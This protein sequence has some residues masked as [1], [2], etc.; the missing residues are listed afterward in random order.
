[1][2]EIM[3]IAGYA[4]FRKFRVYAKDSGNLVDWVRVLLT[5]ITVC[6]IAFSDSALKGRGDTTPQG[7]TDSS[8]SFKLFFAFTVFFRWMKV[9]NSLRGYEFAGALILPVL[10]SLP[11][12]I[13][14]LLVVI[15][16]TMGLMHAYYIFNIYG[17][18]LFRSFMIIYRICFVGDFDWE[19]MEDIDGWYLLPNMTDPDDKQLELEDPELSEWHPFISVILVVAT[20]FVTITMMNI[21]IAVLCDAFGKAFQE[22]DRAFWRTRVR[23]VL[24]ESIKMWTEEA[25]WDNVCRCR[26]PRRSRR[27]S[28][29][30]S[31]PDGSD[32]SENQASESLPHSGWDYVWYCRRSQKAITVSDGH[33]DAE[34][35][36][37]EQDL[38]ELKNQM[39]E[40]ENMVLEMTHAVEHRFDNIRMQY[41][42]E[43]GLGQK[44]NAARSH[45]APAARRNERAAAYA[46][47]FLQSRFQSSASRNSVPAASAGTQF[48]LQ[49]H[50]DA[51]SCMPA[52]PS[53]FGNLAFAL[54]AASS[55]VGKAARTAEE[56]KAAD[57]DH[58]TVST[59]E[60]GALLFTGSGSLPPVPPPS[61]SEI[62]S[63]SRTLPGSIWA[64]NES[65]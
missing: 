45:S 64:E 21:F 6:Y 53:P 14:F 22:R 15:F 40:L 29:R 25:I 10:R 44:R 20:T 51:Q 26:R 46:S 4:Y 24:D 56:K 39:A 52:Q 65:S 9:L 63:P 23:I 41:Q 2:A 5:G 34:G 48:N 7:D 18:D 19:E 13:P 59:S 47:G 11:V 33:I 49:S 43:L 54:S 57:I 42:A 58:H 12:C 27:G 50:R 28:C 61:R 62:D 37:G 55:K 8:Y 36:A 17:V 31:A 35:D 3:Q 16:P 38:A 1:V 30:I 32:E 60:N